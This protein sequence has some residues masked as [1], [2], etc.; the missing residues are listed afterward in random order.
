M[1]DRRKGRR[2]QQILEGLVG[3][4]AQDEPVASVTASV[5]NG[6]EV[7]TAMFP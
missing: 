7:N 4:S 2:G 5:E 3:A 1:L 6:F